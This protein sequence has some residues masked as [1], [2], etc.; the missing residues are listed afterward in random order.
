MILIESQ[1]AP[2]RKVLGQ[3][4]GAAT[5]LNMVVL[6]GDSQNGSMR[7]WHGSQLDRQGCFIALRVKGSR[8]AAQ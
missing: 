6:L 5:E 7:T 1:Y 8:D 2:Q 4:V 3:F